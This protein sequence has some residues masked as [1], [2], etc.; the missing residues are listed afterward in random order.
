MDNALTSVSE[1]A[2]NGLVENMC[3]KVC[4]LVE[5]TTRS[6]IHD[7]YVTNHSTWL[8][9]LALSPKGPRYGKVEM[10]QLGTHVF[11]STQHV[12]KGGRSVLYLKD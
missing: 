1:Q 12:S 5:S 3:L 11:L 8:K 7:C 4:G 10:S 9:Q 6:D 2:C